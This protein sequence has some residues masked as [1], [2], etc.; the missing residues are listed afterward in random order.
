MGRLPDRTSRSDLMTPLQARFNARH[1]RANFN[2]H[3][4]R[5]PRNRGCELIRCRE[6]GSPTTMPMFPYILSHL[7]TTTGPQGK[8]TSVSPPMPSHCRYFALIHIGFGDDFEVGVCRRQARA[9]TSALWLGRAGSGNAPRDVEHGAS[10]INHRPR[11]RRQADVSW[12][13]CPRHRNL[14]EAIDGTL[15]GPAHPWRGRPKGPR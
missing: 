12:H 8:L 2:G 11:D 4:P 5:C 13:H 15:G 10:Y 3:R 14:H 1:S 7:A 9:D 6:D